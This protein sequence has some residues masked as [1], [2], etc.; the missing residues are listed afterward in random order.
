MAID[1]KQWVIDNQSHLKYTLLELDCSDESNK[2]YAKFKCDICGAIRRV[3]AKSIYRNNKGKESMHGERCSSFFFNLQDKEL[4]EKHRKQFRAFYRYAKERCTNPNSKDYGTY[5]GKWGFVDYT[6]YYHSC[7]EAYKEAV[8]KYKDSSL[9]IDRV[10]GAKGYEEGNVR[11]VP[12]EVNLRNKDNVVPIRLENM[13]TGELFIEPSLGM[14]S[15]RL[16]GD[17]THASAIDRAIKRDGIF[18]KVW[19][20]SYEE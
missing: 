1:Y 5:Q 6:H 8:L 2:L 4:G 19:K 9:S 14:A 12:M 11:F 20:V 16:F 13:V 18:L 15:R 3:E 10:D 17:T 7:W